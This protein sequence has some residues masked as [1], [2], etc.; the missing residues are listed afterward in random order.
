MQ[1]YRLSK[2][3]LNT[4]L[5]A[6]QK[7]GELIAPVMEDVVRFKSLANISDIY[8][9]HNAYFPLKEYFFAQQE[10]LFRFDGEKFVQPKQQIKKR[11][12]FGIRRCDLNAISHQDIV[13]AEVNDPYY[14]AKRKNTTLIGYHCNSAPS[15]YCFCG[16]LQLKEFFDLMVYDKKNHFL[17]EVGT[18][19]GK[20]MIKQHQKLFI[21]TDQLITEK[22]NIFL[23]QTV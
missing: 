11:M 6:L 8:L 21:K 12:F 15:K 20:A 7:E 2:T 9:K 19:K 17:V 3:G 18:D 10:T 23:V 22:E 4:W 1:V 5:Q 13:F 16:S 14:L